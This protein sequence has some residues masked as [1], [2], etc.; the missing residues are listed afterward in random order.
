M[1]LASYLSAEAARVRFVYGSYGKP[2][3]ATPGEPSLTFNWSH[4]GDLALLAVT[5]NREV[6]VDIERVRPGIGQLELAGALAAGEVGELAAARG[7]Q[8]DITFCR[9][10][11]RKE[12]FVKALG[13]GASC[14][15]HRFQVSA[16]PRDARLVR[17]EWDPGEVARWSLCDIDLGTEF[18]AALAV[19]GVVPPLAQFEYPRDLCKQRRLTPRGAV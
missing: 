19:A 6:G 5:A 17:V 7:T 12:A 11:A 9:I 3:I 10:W 16:T 13:R 18:A 4:S 1:I 8:R 15:L 14:P 2:A